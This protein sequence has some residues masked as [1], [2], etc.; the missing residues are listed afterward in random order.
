[1]FQSSWYS[2]SVVEFQPWNLTHNLGCWDHLTKLCFSVNSPCKEQ[3]SHV[4]TCCVGIQA[5]LSTERFRKTFFSPHNLGDSEK[6]PPTTGMVHRQKISPLSSINLSFSLLSLRYS[7]APLWSRLC[8]LCQ[9]HHSQ[10]EQ[11]SA[12][13]WKW[14]LKGEV[15]ILPCGLPAGWVQSFLRGYS[16]NQGEAARR[17]VFELRKEFYT[18]SLW[19]VYW[20]LRKRERNLPLPLWKKIFIL[21]D[22]IYCHISNFQTRRY[23]KWQDGLSK[24]IFWHLLFRKGL[25]RESHFPSWIFCFPLMYLKSTSQET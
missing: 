24:R 8:Y 22:L 17:N 2:T 14:V 25:V 4:T 13:I 10:P 12:A 7:E 6:A 11:V 20:L 19:I 1:M 16:R 5:I 3:L 21:W 15:S 18:S 23:L 9:T